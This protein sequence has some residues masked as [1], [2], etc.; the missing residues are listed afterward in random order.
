MNQLKKKVLKNQTPEGN[1]VA[2][3]RPTHKQVQ[4][5]QHVHN[6]AFREALENKALLKEC[7]DKYL[8][9]QGLWDDTKQA[10]ADRLTKVILDGEKTLARRKHAD[11]TA[12]K[13]SEAKKIAFDMQ[14]SRL[15]MVD[16]LSQRRAIEQNTAQAVAENTRFNYLVSVCTV[17]NDTGKRVFS[18]VDDYLVRTREE[19]YLPGTEGAYAF[20]A[21]QTLAE[22]MTD[23]D[24][25]AEKKLPENVFLKKYGFV[26]E[27]MQLV[28][29]QGRL[30]DRDGRLIDEKGRFINEAGL[31]IDRDGNRVDEEGNYV[32][33]DA[34]EFLDDDGNPL[35]FEQ[36][37]VVSGAVESVPELL[38]QTP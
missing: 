29:K 12:V 30:V 1:A 10:E 33:E 20:E 9:E 24:T 5:A 2:V 37:E 18:S 26:N 27:K 31:L 34:G 19:A 16:L 3:E 36:P 35:F 17:Y 14:D 21:A 32:F 13:L 38:S 4:D 28:D 15:K 11:G 22:M 25:E 23:F 7:L 6:R 8:R